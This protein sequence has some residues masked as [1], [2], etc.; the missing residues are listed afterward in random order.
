MFNIFPNPV[1]KT[2]NINYNVERT[3]LVNIGVYDSYGRH[4][5]ALFSSTQ[6]EGLYGIQW[7]LA[8]NN[9]K[10][11]PKGLY[12]IKLKIDNVVMSRKV[13]VN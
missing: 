10:K 11:L 8:G 1:N 12:I 6:P 3:A 2:L 4:I 5:T 7:N 13:V 9:G